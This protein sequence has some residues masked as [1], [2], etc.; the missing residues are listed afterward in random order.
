MYL[1]SLFILLFVG[2]SLL[3]HGQHFIGLSKPEIT[4]KMQASM[5]DFKMDK[6]MVNHSFNYLKYVD[7]ITEQ[8]LLFF[9]SD[10]DIC[11]YVR[12][13]SDY[14]NLNDRIGELNRLHKKVS[15]HEWVYEVKGEQFSV[16]LKEDEWY[17]T[18]SYR[19]K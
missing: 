4:A 18:V 13:I 15:A 11:T 10:G 14:S 1:K 7:K 2:Y 5:P 19:K 17:F 12:M 9:L 8:T 6:S 3:S 16:E